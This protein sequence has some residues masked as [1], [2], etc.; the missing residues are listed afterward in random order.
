MLFDKQLYMVHLL[1]LG[2]AACIGLRFGDDSRLLVLAIWKL[3][4]LC[5]V[6]S[7]VRT[8]VKERE[9]RRAGG[10]C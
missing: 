9:Q 5:L 1:L 10:S 7:F 8:V 3:S 6:G 2:G 4:V